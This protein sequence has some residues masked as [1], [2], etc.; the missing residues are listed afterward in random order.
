MDNFK[1]SEK[2]DRKF[3]VKIL[4][5]IYLLW[6]MLNN[7]TH[8]SLWGD[9]W[10]EFMVSKRPILNGDM[11]ERVLYTYQPPIYNW[12]MHFWLELG[13]SVAWF[14]FFNIIPGVITLLAVYKSIKKL[15]GENAALIS[16]FVFGSMYQWIY[17]VQECSEYC[18]MV[19][20]LAC[21]L[22][23]FINAIEDGRARDMLLMVAMCIGAMYSQYGAFFVVMPLLIIYM[24]HVLF[25]KDKKNIINMLI[26]YLVALIGFAIPL[27]VFY[28]KIQLAGNE[29]GDH[30]TIE[31]GLSQLA[32]LF[33]VFGGLVGYFLN[34]IQYKLLYMVIAVV[35]LIIAGCGIYL[36]AKGRLSLIK[37]YLV[38]GYFVSY[39]MYYVLVTVQIY[40]M[41][42][43]G[44]SSGYYSR[45]GYFFLPYTIITFAVI[46]Y[47]MLKLL[48]ERAGCARMILTAIY[49]VLFFFGLPGI[50]SNWDKSYDDQAYQ[51][52]L[53]NDGFKETT[54]NLGAARYTYKYYK[55]Y[56]SEA[57]YTGEAVRDMNMDIDDLDENSFWVWESGWADYYTFDEI[58]DKA[59]T[60]GYDITV[61]FDA[62]TTKL[63][64]CVKI[65]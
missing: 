47:E 59:K 55:K 45:Y 65:K 21:A 58:L 57:D 10:V 56:V 16:T 42:H 43:P 40:A 33:I 20:F 32:H 61:Y 18:I 60:E 13:D 24:V 54:Y 23:F 14:R 53:S 2:I 27:Y 28:A 5:S 26:T 6:M 36:I 3:V 48:G 34:I 12:V 62:E 46:I 7:F 37:K 50:V 44:Q 29:V 63:A 49:C 1:L 35:G 8:S 19:C 39:V 25:S 11:Y 4:L 22:Y 30:S 64:H 41:M 9:E 31:F 38:I 51:V 15:I 52:W 17:C